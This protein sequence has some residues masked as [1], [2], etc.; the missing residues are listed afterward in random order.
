MAQGVERWPISLSQMT[1]IILPIVQ[2]PMIKGALWPNSDSSGTTRNTTSSPYLAISLTCMC[3]IM[4][5]SRLVHFLPSPTRFNGWSTKS[6]SGRTG[7]PHCCMKAG[8]IV[9][10]WLPLSAKAL[11]FLPSIIKSTSVSGPIQCVV[12]P[13]VTTRRSRHCPITWTFTSGHW[14][15]IAGHADYSHP[16]HW[17]LTAH[18][19]I[20]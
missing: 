18:G 6:T 3:R 5:P 9:F 11:T 8:M 1:L 12:G 4:N 20:S 13:P 19:A 17:C 14:F 2:V 7:N 16:P 15:E 10:T